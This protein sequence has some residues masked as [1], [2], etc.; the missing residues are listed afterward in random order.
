M[1]ELWDQH[2]YSYHGYK[3]FQ[4][5]CIQKVQ[6]TFGVNAT[7]A[8]PYEYV[9]KQE[10]YTG[11]NLVYFAQGSFGTEEKMQC[12]DRLVTESTH[13]HFNFCKELN[14]NGDTPKK[15]KTEV[16]VVGKNVSCD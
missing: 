14:Y 4:S 12:P 9:V 16:K 6:F 2:Q 11:S 8:A 7:G 5:L 10:V 3:Y 1:K 13:E 15:Y